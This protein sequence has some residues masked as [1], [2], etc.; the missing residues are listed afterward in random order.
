MGCLEQPREHEDTD[1]P[2]AFAGVVVATVVSSVV[3]ACSGVLTV[4]STC[5]PSCSAALPLSSGCRHQAFLRARFCETVGFS[6]LLLSPAPSLR[7]TR[8]KKPKQRTLV[9]F[10]GSHMPCLACL[11]LLFPRLLRFVLL[12]FFKKRKI[13]LKGGT[14]LFLNTALETQFLFKELFFDWILT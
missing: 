1:F 13:L 2:P 3:S 6:K 7:R 14:I 9:N 10:L 12:T 8:Q 4:L 5:F 11:L